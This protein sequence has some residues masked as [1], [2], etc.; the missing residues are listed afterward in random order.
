MPLA[1]NLFGALT[2]A[3]VGRD[4]VAPIQRELLGNFGLSELL[5]RIPAHAGS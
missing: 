4:A 2:A 3:A 1:A 5:P